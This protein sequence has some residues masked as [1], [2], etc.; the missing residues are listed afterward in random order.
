L[1]KERK[2]DPLVADED[3]PPV[4]YHYTSMDVLLKIVEHRGIWATNARF[5][6]D[7]S[8]RD[9]FI[10]LVATSMESF[11]GTSDDAMIDR[12]VHGFSSYRHHRPGFCEIPFIASFSSEQDSLAQWRAYCPHGNGVCIGFR[13]D[14]LKAAKVLPA[15][16]RSLDDLPVSIAPECFFRK[17]LY[18]S[19]KAN[20]SELAALVEASI[21]HTKRLVK[22]SP[23]HTKMPIEDQLSERFNDLIEQQA[24]AC[25]DFAFVAES[26]Y[27][28]V[29]TASDTTE[30]V[31]RYRTAK[32]SVVPYVA[33]AL[34]DS[35][36]F[37]NFDDRYGHAQGAWARRYSPFF[38]Q[39]VMIGPNPNGD[40]SKEVLNTL[41][42][43]MSR[44]V[45]VRV[46]SIPYRDWL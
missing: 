11:R 2:S 14:S 10:D 15:P 24:A 42:E 39:E 29:V 9:H 33:V 45:D 20:L 4:V 5:L 43:G 36:D 25:K 16:G 41:F 27:R 31:L 13:T 21:E 32:T 30:K 12:L 35:E 37:L 19:H 17:V 28:V 40:L 38:I 22:E 44:T 34:A 6:N 8:E 3:C 26:E 1:T 23:W 7:I 18:L 46:S